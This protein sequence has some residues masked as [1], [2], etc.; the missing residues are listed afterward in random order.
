MRSSEAFP[1][2]PAMAFQI[3]VT[4]HRA[5][6]QADLA[7]LT[8]A[9][10]A[11]FQAV[12]A[13]ALALFTADQATPSPLYRA[14]APL[15]RCV[16]G[17]AEG[18][19]SILADAAQAEGWALVAV[20][21]FAQ[22]EFA[23]DFPDEAALARYHHLLAE[24]ATVSELDGSRQRG[25]EPYADVGRQ[26]VEQ[27]DLLLAIWDGMPPRGP[28]GTGDVVQ[29]ARA[30]G[31]PVA[32]LPPTGPATLAWCH[33]GSG[34][35][36]AL[37]KAA[38]LP[39]DDGSGFPRR[40][41]TEAPPPAWL[42]RAAVRW[43]ERT[44]LLGTPQPASSKPATVVTLPTDAA[45]EDYFEPADR[46]AGDYAA[47][48]RA[49]GLMR[50]TLTLPATAGSFI[51]SFGPEWLRPFGYLVQFGSLAAIIAFSTK[52]GWDQ[53]QAHFVAYRAIAE[54]LRNAR[55]LA[56][57]GAA[58]LAPGAAVHQAVA[59]DWTAWYSRAVLRALGLSPCRLAAAAIEQA[60]AALHMRTTEQ[61]V[62]LRAHADRYSLL[63]R[64]LKRIGMALVVTGIAAS[65]V[66]AILQVWNA[67]APA[68]LWSNELALLLP[69]LAPLFL[70]LL[71]FGEYARLATRYRAV[72]AALE[73]QLTLLN[74]APAGRE[75]ALATAR[76]ITDVMLAETADWQ[77]IIKARVISAL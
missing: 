26:I 49:A 35:I 42:A 39:P 76:R 28:G 52:G 33:P 16:C 1:P 14:E 2:R 68:L 54:F 58:A 23:H 61:I 37:V 41:F 66:R 75:P 63:A 46:L 13:E 59:A 56:P 29:L 50:Y 45:L 43:F 47:R 20:L 11:L 74:S 7:G 71:G 67:N 10:R 19:D 17:L 64:R 31:R 18:A 9:A 34:D 12:R 40:Y 77:L 53:S 15:L 57:F 8:A 72:A 6:P 44:I 48:Y 38:L 5:L 22:T 55:L 30:W 70:G 24:A 25:G 51:A 69:A 32:T 62:Y 27:S 65:V 36:A 3:G 60:I 21:P 4:G 73:Q